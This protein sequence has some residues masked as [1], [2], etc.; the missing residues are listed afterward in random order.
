MKLFQILAH[1]MNSKINELSKL[2]YWSW[3]SSM[4][5]DS[6]T[7]RASS[8]LWRE[9]VYGRWK[10]QWY[11]AWMFFVVVDSL[12]KLLNKPSYPTADVPNATA[13]KWRHC[14]D[15]NDNENCDNGDD[16]DYDDDGDKSLLQA[17]KVHTEIYKVPHI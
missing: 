16:D 1:K 2:P 11:P 12:S 7:L 17:S 3:L 9:S 8:L 4:I 14:N 6:N 13:P 15:N 10:G 5:K